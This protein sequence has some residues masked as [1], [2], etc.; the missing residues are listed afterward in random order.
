MTGQ[1]I[2]AALIAIAALAF[3]A[4]RALAR[5][6]EA[7]ARYKATMSRKLQQVERIRKA[8][9]ITADLKRDLR[10]LHRQVKEMREHN[11]RL[12]DEMRSLSR[13]E[14]RI[15]VLDERR[16]VSDETWI[17]TV[18]APAPEPDRPFPPWSGNRRFQVWAVD[19]DSA[20]AKVA[21]RFPPSGGFQIDSVTGR[22]K[23]A[24]DA[25]TQTAAASP[26]P[27]L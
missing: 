16:T 13:P 22:S 14:N 7:K 23:S 26:F 9:R 1:I 27:T 3:G 15:Y 21:R 8:A 6:R 2:F 19:Q 24:V 12:R 5:V 10:S 11:E 25:T 18:A 4:E 17:V 20:K